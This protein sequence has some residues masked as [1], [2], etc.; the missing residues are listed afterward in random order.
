MGTGTSP[1]R[2]RALGSVLGLS[3]RFDDLVRG[4]HVTRDCAGTWISL[5]APADARGAQYLVVLTAAHCVLSPV[6]ARS[7]IRNV[8]VYGNRFAGDPEEQVWSFWRGSGASSVSACPLEGLSAARH[9]AVVFHPEVRSALASLQRPV[10]GDELLGIDR[11]E[12]GPNDNDLLSFIGAQPNRL[13][14]VAMLIIA[15]DGPECDGAGSCDGMWSSSDVLGPYP[16]RLVDSDSDV[17]LSTSTIGAGFNCTH[18]TDYDTG[19]GRLDFGDLRIGLR[20]V[21]TTSNV[22]SLVR[23]RERVTWPALLVTD[24]DSGSGNFVVR[25][26]VTAEDLERIGPHGSLLPSIV[27]VSGVLSTVVRL[28]RTETD[29]VRR[30]LYVGYGP[31]RSTWCEAR[32][33]L[34]LPPGPGC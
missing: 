26:D 34:S 27:G 14:D 21:T 6:D 33:E 32:R 9:Y 12:R 25:Q 31:T 19:C 23:N 5:D 20:A 18:R 2:A 30:N 13:P 17:A 28:H 7:C 16:S 11:P 15:R 10:S 8:H 22:W 3:F 1:L 4:N 24:G 29:I